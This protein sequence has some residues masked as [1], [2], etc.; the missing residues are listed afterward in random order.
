[1]D[2][3]VGLPRTQRRKDSI[4]VAVDRSSKIAHFT[5]HTKTN[6]IVPV[7]ELYSKETI[8]LHGAP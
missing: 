6:D 7:A 4:F 1:M 2:F 5:A 8:R 3:T